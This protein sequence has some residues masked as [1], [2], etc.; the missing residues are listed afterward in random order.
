MNKRTQHGAISNHVVKAVRPTE[1]QYNAVDTNPDKLW[2]RKK[3]Q[4][5]GLIC[6]PMGYVPE[7][8]L[9][10]KDKRKTEAG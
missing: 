1:P 10:G 4:F 8:F 7:A 6:P 3:R 5:G 9:S 2:L